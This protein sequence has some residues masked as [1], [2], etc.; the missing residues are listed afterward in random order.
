MADPAILALAEHV[1]KYPPVA[2]TLP[3]GS[4]DG[5][6]VTRELLFTT[7]GRALNRNAFNRP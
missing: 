3:W 4:P 2:V 7:A 1:R 6:R 5:K